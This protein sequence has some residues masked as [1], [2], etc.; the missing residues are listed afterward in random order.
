MKS[1]N[2]QLVMDKL[3]GVLKFEIRP[4]IRQHVK[5]FAISNQT[6][7]T[8]K[9]Y[10]L[11]TDISNLAAYPAT[12][13]VGQYQSI[14]QPLADAI[15]H[16][17]IIAYTSPDAAPENLTIYLSDE[18]INQNQTFAPSFQ[19]AGGIAANV[20]IDGDTVGLAKATQLPDA[21]TGL[22][23]LK[24]SLQEVGAGVILPTNEKG[25]AWQKVTAT[26]AGEIIV[27]DAPGVVFALRQDGAGAITLHDGAGVQ[28][29]KTGEYA[30]NF[31]LKCEN[32]IIVNFDAAGAAWI[33]FE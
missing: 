33:L 31:P 16:G 15:N 29:W 7:N 8:L 13:N 25:K 3:S 1:Y 5:F 11:F 18:D 28:A 20:A 17:F 10:P 21:P 12:L 23:N 27:K 19:G 32:S 14:T 2:F 26:A 9:I 24:T 30:E 22:G 6:K 4:D